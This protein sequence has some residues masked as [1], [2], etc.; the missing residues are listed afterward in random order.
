MKSC[1]NYYYL[2]LE[3]EDNF[4][5][6]DVEKC[7]YLNVELETYH[8]MMKNNFNATILYADDETHFYKLRDAKAALHWLESILIAK[9]LGGLNNEKDGN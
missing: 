5:G 8:D 3:D 7:L 9:K 1:E 6:D 2:Y 4:I